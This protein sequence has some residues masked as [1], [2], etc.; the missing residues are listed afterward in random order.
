MALKDGLQNDFYTLMLGKTYLDT[1]FT[2]KRVIL[3]V[4]KKTALDKKPSIVTGL[5]MAFY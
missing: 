3:S 1:G 5:M 2:A 4:S